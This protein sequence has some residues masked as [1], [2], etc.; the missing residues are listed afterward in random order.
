MQCYLVYQLSCDDEVSRAHSYT[1]CFVSVIKGNSKLQLMSY[2]TNLSS[3]RRGNDFMI[4]FL[5][6]FFLYKGKHTCN[7]IQLS[8]NLGEKVKL[9]VLPLLKAYIN[10][11]F[12][13]LFLNKEVYI[14]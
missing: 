6:Y 8:K 2:R 3:L 7:C 12:I 1:I 14:C 10:K 4:S 9:S 13:Y 11:G 5:N